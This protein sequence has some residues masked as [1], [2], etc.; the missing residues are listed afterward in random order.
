MVQDPLTGSVG[1]QESGQMREYLTDMQV[2]IEIRMEDLFQQPSS[3]MTLIYMYQLAK[4]VQALLDQEEVAGIVITHGTDSL[5]ETAYYLDLTLQSEKPVVVTG[6]MR[7]QNELGSDGSYHLHQSIRV[8][9]ESAARARGV[10]VVFQDQIHA[11]KY[12]TKTHTNQLAAFQSLNIGPIGR[13]NQ[14]RIQFYHQPNRYSPVVPLAEPHAKVELLK[15]VT[16][17]NPAIMDW[18]LEQDVDGLVIEAFGQGNLPPQILAGCY[19]MLE[20]QIPIVLVSRCLEGQVAG[21]Y[22]YQGGGAELIKAGFLFDEDI[23]GPKARLKLIAALSA[24]CMD[25]M[26]TK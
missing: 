6:A 12:V 11:A 9:A 26:Y 3:H 7:S 13:V 1:L 23:S 21:I 5:E 15:A 8:A 25:Q 14:Q 2:D 17:M 16:D 18:M 4:H 22:G 10:M 19:K 20:K 24:N